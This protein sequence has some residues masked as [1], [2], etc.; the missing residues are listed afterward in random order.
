MKRENPLIEICPGITRRTVANGK[1]MYQM[2][3]TLAA[4]S[5]M[6]E[7]RYAQEQIVDFLVRYRSYQRHRRSCDY[8]PPHLRRCRQCIISGLRCCLRDTRS[9]TTINAILPGKFVNVRH[10]RSASEDPRRDRQPPPLKLLRAEE[11]RLISGRLRAAPG[12][13]ARARFFFGH[14]ARVVRIDLGKANLIVRPHF[15]CRRFHRYLA[16]KSCSRN[17]RMAGAAIAPAWCATSIPFLKIDIVG[18]A[19][20]RKRRAKLGSSSVLTLATRT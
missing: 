5:R 19:L 1:T 6:P 8:E 18:I 16:T 10:C 13:K 11:S 15:D 14:L 7:H 17:L 20:T 12:D 4:G 2:I 9:T 3:A